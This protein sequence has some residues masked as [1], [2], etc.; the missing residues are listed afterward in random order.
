M[1]R[2][3][4]E[5]KEELLKL[6]LTDEQRKILSD[7]SALYNRLPSDLKNKLEG[8]MHVFLYQVTFDREGFAEVTEEMRICVAAEAC[9]LILTRGYDSYSKF[10]RVTISREP[11]KDER[12][13]W[14]GWADRIEVS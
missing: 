11:L 6:Q 5:D 7:C 10:R 9:V 12:G 3:T 4:R 14:A 1:C 8:L 13:V 2:V